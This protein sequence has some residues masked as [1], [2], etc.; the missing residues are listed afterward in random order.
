MAWPVRFHPEALL[1]LT[2]GASFYGERFTTLVG[3]AIALIA[4]MP[5]TWPVW[6]GRPG[7]HRRVLT[8]LPYAIV[9]AIEEETIFVVAVE[10]TKRRP[11]YWLSRLSR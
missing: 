9:Y 11:G 8:K 3:H 2:D 7:M 10:H 5:R 6:P 1:E 4:E